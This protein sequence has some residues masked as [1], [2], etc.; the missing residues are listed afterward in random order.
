MSFDADDAALDSTQRY[1]MEIR[2]TPL[3][4]REEEQAL[5]RRAV[6]GD[7]E[8]KAEMMQANLRLVVSVAKHFTGRGLDLLDLIQEGNIGLGIAVERFDPERGFKFSTYAVWWI[9]QS[10]SRAISDQSRTIR[11]PV[12]LG[13]RMSKVNRATEKL[14]HELGR[15]PTS[16]EI[17][18]DIGIEEVAVVTAQEATLNRRLLSLDMPI[19][20]DDDTFGDVMAGSDKG[21]TEDE[22]VQGSLRSEL[23]NLLAE[24]TPKERFVLTARFGIGMDDRQTLA[25][26][27]DHL[28]VSR[29]RIRQIEATAIAKLRKH[30]DIK[31]LR[32]YLDS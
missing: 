23:D 1:L 6:A 2:E 21:V 19:G 15:R 8:A 18:E 10:V 16:A 3:L 13:E 7:V 31:E 25:E 5:A 20:D 32:E 30:K 22:V 12:H 14:T 28:G 26:L 24:L 27:G 29:E 4:T 9:R 17:A 11:I